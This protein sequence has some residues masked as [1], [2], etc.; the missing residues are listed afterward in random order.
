[1]KATAPTRSATAKSTALSAE[2]SSSRVAVPADNRPEAIQLRQIQQAIDS[3]PQLVQQKELIDSIHASAHVAMQRRQRNGV[4]EAPARRHNESVG[5]QAAG[6]ASQVT[7]QLKET[8]DHGAKSVTK[9][10]GAQI[11]ATDTQKALAAVVL[12]GQ[13]GSG[14]S[15]VFT[16]DTINESQQWLKIGTGNDVSRIV[17]PDMDE[18][19]RD[20]TGYPDT[21]RNNG[22][23][24]EQNCA[25]VAEHELIHLKNAQVNSNKAVAGAGTSVSEFSNVNIQAT[26]DDLD[27]DIQNLTTLK[28]S[29]SVTRLENAKA[30]LARRVTYIR[31]DWNTNNRNSE[32][33]AVLRELSRYMNNDSVVKS[34]DSAEW[35]NLKTKIEGLDKKCSEAVGITP[36]KTGCFITTACTQA[37]SLD[38]NCRELSRLRGFRDGYLTSLPSGARLTQ[39]Y[40]RH[41]PRIL[42]LIRQREDEEELMKM[43]YGVVKACADAVEQGDNFFAFRAY[44]EM[45]FLLAEKFIPQMTDEIRLILEEPQAREFLSADWRTSDLIARL[46]KKLLPNGNGR[47]GRSGGRSARAA[48]ECALPLPRRRHATHARGER[49]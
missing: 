29:M 43:M 17:L 13:L 46:R 14:D 22:Q 9:W 2:T 33:P 20:Q 25:M 38:D 5:A 34:T 10:Y 28:S 21:L 45:M 37:M 40:Y 3:S 24:I 35:L 48:S 32:A 15:G 41:A 42:H 19:K 39:L 49:S 23:T 31:T 44:C 11:S 27:T 12:S 7:L 26:L 36:V 1:M 30:Y 18:I 6:S 8:K 4:I 16:S 47:R